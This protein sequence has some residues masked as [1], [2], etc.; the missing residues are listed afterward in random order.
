MLEGDGD[1]EQ[2]R[3][4]AGETHGWVRVE[5]GVRLS[6]STGRSRVRIAAEL[7]HIRGAE[8][9]RNG[10][11]TARA[12]ENA[13]KQRMTNT[14]RRSTPQV[15]PAALKPWVYRMGPRKHPREIATK[16]PA[17]NAEPMPT[18][19]QRTKRNLSWAIRGEVEPNEKS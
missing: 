5:R 12:T 2:E 10:H 14:Q 13:L 18:P 11:D 8:A 4:N 9:A 7:S 16:T 17:D 3:G 15:G 19:S 6:C 1:N